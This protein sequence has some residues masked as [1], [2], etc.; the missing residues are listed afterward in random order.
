METIWFKDDVAIENSGISHTFNDLWNRTLSLLNADTTHT[1]RYSCH[2]STKSPRS[3]PVIAAANVTILGNL[4]TRIYFSIVIEIDSFRF[5]IQFLI[6]TQI[7][8]VGHYLNFVCRKT[9][10]S[11]KSG[12]G[13]TRWFRQ[14]L[15]VTVPS[16]WL[17][18][19]FRSMVQKYCWC[20]NFTRQQVITKLL[21]ISTNCYTKSFSS[22]RIEFLRSIQKRTLKIFENVCP[23]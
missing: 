6:L 4:Y 9:Y 8:C 17:T 7:I 12:L 3:A 15:I 19:T 5:F 16:S 23:Y 18:W 14:D 22:D 13:N 10:A 11:R 21:L 20:D 2:V 1:G